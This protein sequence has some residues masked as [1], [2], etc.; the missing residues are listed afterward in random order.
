MRRRGPAIRRT[1]FVL[2]LLVLCAAGCVPALSAGTGVA[3]LVTADP[4]AVP[5]GGELVI[6]V[7][8]RG[9]SATRLEG[10]SFHIRSS[11]TLTILGAETPA[12]EYFL[13]TSFNPDSGF[14][15]ATAAV[16]DGL[17]EG[18]TW[19]LLVLTCRVDPEAAEDPFLSVSDSPD[20]IPDPKWCVFS[21]DENGNETDLACDLSAAYCS[22]SLLLPER[23][24]E[25]RDAEAAEDGLEE[26]QAESSGPPSG[27]DV[28]AQP[29]TAEPEGGAPETPDAEAKEL[30]LPSEDVSA[31]SEKEDEHDRT[32]RADT[33]SGESSSGAEN[34]TPEEE[35]RTDGIRTADG[36]R[37]RQT[38]LIA[39]GAALFLLIACAAAVRNR[40]RR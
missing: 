21:L 14:F 15:S 2:C 18:D 1:V 30:E 4:P 5:P 3:L 34:K 25:E 36:M 38:V 6:A 29:E 7:S 28:P 35:L 11:E 16:S 17:P 12:E 19:V 27:A 40:R 22:V 20:G 9:L 13:L 10:I 8:V 31:F 39:S 33:P 37:S 32:G 24:D 23:P 26:V